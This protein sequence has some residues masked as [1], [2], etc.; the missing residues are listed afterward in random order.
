[1]S[2]PPSPTR[3]PGRLRKS[4]LTV[5]IATVT[6]AIVVTMSLALYTDTESVTAND[7]A[8]GTIDLTAAPATAVVTMPVMFPGD[9]VTAPLTIANIGTAELRYA[10]TSA[11]TEDVLA[12]ALVLTVKDSVSDCSDA[13]FAA[14]GNVLYSGVLGT[15]ASI[16]V[17]GDTTP[18][19]DVGDRV[20]AAAGS[21]VLCLNVALPLATSDVTEGLATTATF[22]FDG[23]QTV[24][25]P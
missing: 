25:N 14:D 6:A 9:Q 10:M 13:G 1:M 11:T 17:F 12:G 19:A 22:T 8:S 4:A 3:A 21:E 2:N 7:F 23:E 20:L 5:A 18:G 24:N 15:L 16:P